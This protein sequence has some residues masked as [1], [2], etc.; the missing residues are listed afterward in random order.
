MNCPACAFGDISIGYPYLKSVVTA[1]V[2]GKFHRY[3]GAGKLVYKGQCFVSEL[4]QFSYKGEYG[5]QSIKGV[6]MDGNNIGI[7]IS[8]MSASLPK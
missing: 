1:W 3:M 5:R 8:A 6:P 7:Y 4:V 2:E